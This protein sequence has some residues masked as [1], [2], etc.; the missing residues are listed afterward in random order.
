MRV[1]RARARGSEGFRSH[2][3][4]LFGARWDELERLLSLPSAKVL[5]LN[6]FAETALRVR[7]AAGLKP[8]PGLPQCYEISEAA[9][10]PLS[11]D[12]QGLSSGYVMDAAS[13]VAARALSVSEGEAVLDLCAAPG[14]KA[15]VLLEALERLGTLTL[16]DRSQRRATRLRAVLAQ[17][18]PPS[19]LQ[20]V[21]VRMRDARKWGLHEAEAYDAILVDAPCSSERHV[22]RD[23]AELGKWSPSRIRRLQAD[24]YAILASAA[25]ALRPGGRLVYATCALA[26]DENDGVI[27][28]LLH[29]GRHPLEPQAVSAALGERT[30]FGWQIQP[31]RH[32]YGPGY[33]AKL[34]KR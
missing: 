26:P 21:R 32:V 30:R 16:N 7:D 27:E 15:L 11:I 24:Q 14:G 6:G 18:A 29:R 10:G 31:D 8:V 25:R 20:R 17:Y 28:R 34:V 33:F 22:L 23:A 19:V 13:V 1:D 9:T 12:R 5:R 2:Y 3:R 4:G